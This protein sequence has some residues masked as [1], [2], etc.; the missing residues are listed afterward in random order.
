M[1]PRELLEHLEKA[2]EGKDPT[3]VP[4][5]DLEK[6]LPKHRLVDA[7]IKIYRGKMADSAL[8]AIR[9]IVNVRARRSNAESIFIDPQK[10][11][12]VFIDPPKKE[13]ESED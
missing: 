8:V 11:D 12:T 10:D 3:I 4:V 7:L 9:T 1:K 6:D 5:E 2:L 13:K